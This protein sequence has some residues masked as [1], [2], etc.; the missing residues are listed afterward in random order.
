MSNGPAAGR[1]RYDCSIRTDTFECM[2][3]T[4]MTFTVQEEL[5]VKCLSSR[6]GYEWLI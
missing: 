2:E 3:S 4:F 1:Q 6:M 5:I